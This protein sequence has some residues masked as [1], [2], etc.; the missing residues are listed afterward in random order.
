MSSISLSFFQQ[1]FPSVTVGTYK[2]STSTYTNLTLAVREYADGFIAVA[3]KHT[4]SDGSLAEQYNRDTGAPISAKDL[5]W[6][7]AALLTANAA[8]SGFAQDSWGAGELSLP[9]TCSGNPGVVV[10]TTFNV[11]AT[12]VFGGSSLFMALSLPSAHSSAFTENIY[13][14]GSTDAL[15]NWSPN[16]ALLLSAINYPIW[17]CEY[18]TLFS[19]FSATGDAYH[20]SNC[21]SPG[22][23]TL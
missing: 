16:V 18:M 13:I 6:S 5:T 22:K 12:T 8:R 15:S 3:A 4:P 11:E 17:S 2:S 23:C 1:F 21:G 9:K 10:A 20:R 14:T 7:Y 19:T